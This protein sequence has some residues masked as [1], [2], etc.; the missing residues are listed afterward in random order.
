MSKPCL[1][2]GFCDGLLEGTKGTWMCTVFQYGTSRKTPLIPLLATLSFS[3]MEM[4]S[5][6]LLLPLLQ[7]Q[8]HQVHFWDKRQLPVPNLADGSIR[9][10]ELT[11]GEC[12][13]GRSGKRKKALCSLLNESCKKYLFLPPA[14]SL[15]VWKIGPALNVTLEILASFTNKGVS[16]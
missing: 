11:E 2:M 6:T 4:Q 16:L 9:F 10:T 8:W 1:L 12:E 13:E 14:F 7:H 15:R 3:T 5:P